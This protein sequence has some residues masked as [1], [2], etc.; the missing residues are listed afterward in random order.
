M[1]DWLIVGGGIHGTYLSNHLLKSGRASA[2]KLM[3]L[4]P[5]DAPLALW[6]RRTTNTRMEY[7]RSPAEHNLDVGP[8]ALIRFARSRTGFGAEFY[9]KYQRPSLNL[10][11]SHCNHVIASGKLEATRCKGTAVALEQ[12]NGAYIVSTESGAL[13]ARRV[14]LSLGNDCLS[15]PE[16]AKVLETSDAPIVHIF[17]PQL[18][19]ASRKDWTRAV[20]IGGGISGLQLALNL[21]K[22][23]PGAVTLLHSKTLKTSQ[24]DADPCWLDKRCLNLLT[25]QADYTERRRIVDHARN[26][27]SFP[28]DVRR[29]LERALKCESIKCIESSVCT[30]SAD[31]NQVQLKLSNERTIESDLVILATGFERCLPG[32]EFLKNTIDNL[33]LSCAPCGFPTIDKYL[34]WSNN[35]YVTGALAELVIGPASRNIV[36]AR[37]AAELIVSADIPR[38]YRPRELSYYYFD[39]RRSG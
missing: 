7:L 26:W 4:D 1:L 8:G 31:R 14:I 21:A 38:K 5:H 15:I 25:R 17:S 30:A 9:S 34:R 24:F 39:K 3:V 2:D 20:V 12:K 13:E 18:Q 35:L 11:N 33:S 28:E 36:G 10:F 22:Q 19:E 23:K 27:G 6:K 32:G 16:W 37:L 29:Q